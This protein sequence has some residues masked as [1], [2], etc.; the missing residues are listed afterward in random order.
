MFYVFIIN[1]QRNKVEKKIYFCRKPHKD[2][3]NF[4]DDTPKLSFSFNVYCN[5]YNSRYNSCNS[6]VKNGIILSFF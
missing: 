5:N 1:L 6:K 2:E 4:M 3:H